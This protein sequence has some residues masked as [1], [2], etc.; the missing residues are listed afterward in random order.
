MNKFLS[1]LSGTDGTSI[2]IRIALILLATMLVVKII[3]AFS[4]RGDVQ[5]TLYKKFLYN[6][7]IAILYITG[8]L[9]IISQIPGLG[10]VVKTLLAGS[11]ILA[12]AL[13]LSAQESLSNVISGFFLTLFKPF[14]VGDRVKLVNSNITGIVEDITLRHTVIKTFINSRVVIPNSS[15]NK[16]IIENSNLIDSKASSF[17][18]INISYDSDIHKAM[19]IMAQIIGD[20]PLYIDTRT[21]EDIDNKV[22]KVRVYVRELGES[23]I[24]LRA[25]MWTDTVPKN[26]EA[27]SDVRISIKEAFEANGIEIPYKKITINT[28]E[29]KILGGDKKDEQ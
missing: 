15:I 20:H 23:S 11:G 13:S 14:E 8:L 22:E 16:E 18:D 1:L 17:V 24:A 26:F 21:Q 9:L 19:E 2:V 4:N 12:L 27:C 7:I 6:V 28:E 29:R 3:R 25:N 10:Q 5:S